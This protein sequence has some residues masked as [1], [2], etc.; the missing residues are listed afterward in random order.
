MSEEDVEEWEALVK[1][2]REETIE[3]MMASAFVISV[4]PEK[5]DVKVA[6]ELGLSIMLDKPLMLILMPGATTP[7]RLQRVADHVV[8]ADLDTPDGRE[9]VMRAIDDFKLKM[10]L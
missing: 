4:V 2:T 1:H 3:K 5:A 7:P 8:I 9:Y 6:L 10:G